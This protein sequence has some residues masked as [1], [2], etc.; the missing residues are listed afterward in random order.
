MQTQYFLSCAVLAS[1]Q[2]V[3]THD[4]SCHVIAGQ[5]KS[6]LEVG[7]RPLAG[8]QRPERPVLIFTRAPEILSCW[9]HKVFVTK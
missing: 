7:Y 6:L 9:V 5:I 8:P 4:G 2:D 1:T 3:R